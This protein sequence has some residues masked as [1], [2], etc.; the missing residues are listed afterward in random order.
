MN[1]WLWRDCFLLFPATDM[2]YLSSCDSW[3]VLWSWRS[4]SNNST[5][6]W[7]KKNAVSFQQSWHQTHPD[8][9]L[10]LSLS[11]ALAFPS[12]AVLNN[13]RVF[14]VNVCDN[15]FEDVRYVISHTHNFDVWVYAYIH[16]CVQHS[17]KLSVSCMDVLVGKSLR[18]GREA[19]ALQFQKSCKAIL[20]TPAS[21][22]ELR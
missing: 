19:G 7:L 1:W 18:P 5:D 20:A 8:C 17:W 6:I 4:N 22:W 15:T 11:F 21:I 9:F 10:C 2:E 12:A 14:L 3:K 16:E 13:L